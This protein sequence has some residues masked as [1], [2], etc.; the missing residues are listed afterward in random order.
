[1]VFALLADDFRRAIFFVA[2]AAATDAI[3][4]LLAR[5]F[6]WQS[7][8]GAYLDPIADKV[9]LV[10]LYICLWLS[11]KVPG[12]L[13]AII[14]GRDVLLLLLAGIGLLATKRKEFPP[15]VWGKITTILQVT[16][17]LVVLV[18]AAYPRHVPEELKL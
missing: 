13:L 18:S 12:W 8:L 11:N 7:Q 5:R 14:A 6:H 1:M 4:G 16:T 2:I 15:S 3:D 17:A 9:M 10:N